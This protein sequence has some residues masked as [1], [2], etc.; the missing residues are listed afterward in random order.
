MLPSFSLPFG[1][2]YSTLP[3]SDLGT[4]RAHRDGHRHA[5]AH[6]AHFRLVDTALENE[7]LHVGDHGD[8]RTFVEVVGLDD[9][10]PLFDGDIEHRAGHGRRH[11]I[12]DL[13]HVARSAFF[14]ELQVVVGRC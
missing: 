12:A 4:E 11:Q 9:A 1:E 13:A 14:D 10:A 7:V 8:G 6:L 2:M 5:D 3:L